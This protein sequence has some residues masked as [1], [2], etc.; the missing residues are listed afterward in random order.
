MPTERNLRKN[1]WHPCALGPEFEKAD[2]AEQLRLFKATYWADNITNAE[3][4]VLL[5]QP[6]AK[7]VAVNRSR[8]KKKA[9]GWLMAL[10]RISVL[11]PDLFAAICEQ[12]RTMYADQVKDDYPWH[13]MAP[14]LAG[15][16]AVEPGDKVRLWVDRHDDEDDDEAAS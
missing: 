15:L 16:E 8:L 10:A 6:D 9:S 2:A 13:H 3:W 11:N 1:L 14:G 5:R 7:N 4:P 12:A